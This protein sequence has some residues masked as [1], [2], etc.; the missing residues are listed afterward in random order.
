MLRHFARSVNDIP[1]SSPVWPTIIAP[2]IPRSLILSRSW[3]WKSGRDAARARNLPDCA[4]QG[5]QRSR[6]EGSSGALTGA[7]AEKSGKV[8]MALG[9]S[10]PAKLSFLR[11]RIRKHVWVSPVETL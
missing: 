5:R 2:D 6:I 1:L 10:D 4:A 11:A 7:V 3:L 9:N 8:G